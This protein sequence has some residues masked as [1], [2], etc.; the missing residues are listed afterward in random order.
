MASTLKTESIECSA[1]QSLHVFPHEDVD[2]LACS[3]FF[4]ALEK[5]IKGQGQVVVNI[6]M[7]W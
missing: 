3:G 2:N 1:K 4:V 5:A 6:E 7:I